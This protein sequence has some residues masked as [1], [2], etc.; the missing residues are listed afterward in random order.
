MHNISEKK[1]VQL[2]TKVIV[3]YKYILRYILLNIIT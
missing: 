1:I 3:N 2:I